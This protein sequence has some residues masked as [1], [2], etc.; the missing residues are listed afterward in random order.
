MDVT[1]DDAGASFAFTALLC[2]GLTLLAHCFEGFVEITVGFR[3]SSLSI[4]QTNTGQF[5]QS[6]NCIDIY[7]H[8]LYPFPF[9]SLLSV[10]GAAFSAGASSLSGAGAAFAAVPWPSA[11]A[12]CT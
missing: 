4:G 5:L 7:C 12:A 8:Y 2:L 10:F 11:I 9:T 3:Q 1:S 6:L